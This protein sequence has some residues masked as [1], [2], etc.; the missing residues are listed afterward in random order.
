MSSLIESVKG[1]LRFNPKKVISHFLG[2]ELND[3]NAEILQNMEHIRKLERK[4]ERLEL[5]VYGN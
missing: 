1:F 3:I 4:R 2:E 5:M